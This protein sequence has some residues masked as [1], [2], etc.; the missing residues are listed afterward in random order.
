MNHVRLYFSGVR[1]NVKTV[2]SVLRYVFRVRQT[3]VC[4]VPN[5]S[6]DRDPAILTFIVIPL[7][8]FR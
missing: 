1:P 3:R 6:P 8:R 2:K 4:E 7:G 5:S